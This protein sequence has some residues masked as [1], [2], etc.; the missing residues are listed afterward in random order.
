MSKKVITTIDANLTSRSITYVDDVESTTQLVH[1]TDILVEV[2]SSM[3]Q[4]YRTVYLEQ[5]T[6]GFNIDTVTS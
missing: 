4:E 2:W 1:S 6:N 5:L 3:R